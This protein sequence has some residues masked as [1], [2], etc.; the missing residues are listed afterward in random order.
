MTEPSIEE[1]V[2]KHN[3]DKLAIIISGREDDLKA[4]VLVRLVGD[5]FAYEGTFKVTRDT[6]DPDSTDMDQFFKLAKKSLIE[7][8]AGKKELNAVTA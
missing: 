8:M 4:Q 7:V 1:R 2:S 3:I 6:F 5:R